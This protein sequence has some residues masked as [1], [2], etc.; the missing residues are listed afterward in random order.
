MLYYLWRQE[1][2]LLG[3]DNKYYTKLEEPSVKLIVQRNQSAFEPFSEEVDEAIIQFVR[4]DPQYS[5]YGKRFD[6]FSEQEN[7]DDQMEFVSSTQGQIS[8]DEDHVPTDD[9]L[10]PERNS[11]VSMLLPI[12]SLTVPYE[13]TDDA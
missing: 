2:D 4:N 11:N 6:S 5:I 13:V 8:E 10:I 3:H 1:S 12:N 9:I 7:S